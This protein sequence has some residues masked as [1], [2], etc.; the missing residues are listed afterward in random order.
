[1]EDSVPDWL[2]LFFV[3]IL[4]L[5]LLSST[6]LWN[7][8]EYVISPALSWLLLTLRSEIFEHRVSL[9]LQLSL[10]LEFLRIVGDMLPLDL[11]WESLIHLLEKFIR[12]TRLCI[13]SIDSSSFHPRKSTTSRTHE[14]STRRL[15]EHS[16]SWRHHPSST[17][18][19]L[20]SRASSGRIHTTW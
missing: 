11:P 19:V 2:L 10:G 15:W 13:Q 12:V 3:L 6:H 9:C 14:P 8:V 7:R 5:L 1:M 16:T 17:L 20:E 4:F 18:G